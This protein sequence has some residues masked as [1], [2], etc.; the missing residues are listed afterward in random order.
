MNEASFSNDETK[1]SSTNDVA[2]TAD[3]KHLLQ[4]RLLL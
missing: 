4:Q 3:D 2:M 1:I